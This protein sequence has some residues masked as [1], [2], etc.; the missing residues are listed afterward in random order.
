MLQLEVAPV[1]YGYSVTG[2]LKEYSYF[3]TD[4][5]KPILF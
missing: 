5:S 2:V 3:E 4:I 1:N